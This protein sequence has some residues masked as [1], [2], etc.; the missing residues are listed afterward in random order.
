MRV[1]TRAIKKSTR[2]K[3][4]SVGLALCSFCL[5]CAPSTDAAR[6]LEFSVDPRIELLAAIQMLSAYNDR[7]G[8][9]TRFDFEYKTAM[10]AHF[11]AFAGHPVV[12]MFDAMSMQGFAF[13]IPPRVMLYLSEPPALEV[14]PEFPDDLIA[15]AGGADRLDAFVELMRD[16]ARESDFMRF[17]DEQAPAIAEMVSRTEALTEGADYIEILEDYYG[18]QQHS[19]HFVLAP[20]YHQGGFGPRI[21]RTDGS[22]D[23][24]NIT[25]PRGVVDGYPTFGSAEDLRHVAL[26]EFGHSFVNPTTQRY[27]EDVARYEALYEPIREAMTAIAYEDWESCVN[28]HIIRAVTTRMAYNRDGDEEGDRA[29]KLET[30]RGFMY[31]PAL[32]AKLEVYEAQRDVYTDFVSFYPTLLEAF[33]E[34]L[35]E[36][37]TVKPGSER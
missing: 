17:Y 25:G 23:L 5:S 32:T 31:V 18:M 29:M 35:E 6:R 3:T 21:E 28:E 20:L 9:L 26:H 33:E 30:D 34:L 14:N 11:T 27:R 8:L 15:Q 37:I 1:S 36:E 4:V 7:F 2:V 22:F 12:Q 10:E 24:Y 13:S 16:F 19:Y